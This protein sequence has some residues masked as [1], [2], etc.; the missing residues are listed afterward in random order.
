MHPRILSSRYLHA[1]FVRICRFCRPLSR[2]KPWTATAIIL[3]VA[4]VLAGISA[5]ISADP[6]HATDSIGHLSATNHGS[7]TDRSGRDDAGSSGVTARPMSS[8]PARQ[9]HRHP[10]R[11]RPA[12]GADSRH[13][14]GV[15][16]SARP[17]RRSMRHHPMT[18]YRHLTR[19]QAAH[20][21]HLARHRHRAAHARHARSYLIYDSVTPAAIPSHHIIA[22]Y[23]TGN[24]AVSPA[25]VAGRRVMWIDITGTDPAAAILDVE[26]GDATPSLAASWA[27][28][29]LTA[30]P[31]S[32][33]RI[34]T[35]RSEWPA[36][37]AAVATLP[38]R[39]RSRI[40]WWI[41]DPTGIPHIVPGSDATQWYWGHS[42]DITTATP[43]F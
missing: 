15:R 4:G 10:A 29:R 13:Q 22:T 18:A 2:M 24:Y 30:N 7:T 12:S 6:I 26:P 14:A 25:Q 21:R 32:L 31:R 37:Q 9:D 42:Y 33:A 19:S 40:R 17:E 43:H 39:M 8:P 35:M 1:L 28:H 16:H 11:N 3:A 41:A 36:V 23:A 34:Y 20:Q 5:S 38:P 27:W